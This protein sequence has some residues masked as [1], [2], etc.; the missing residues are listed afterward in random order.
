MLYLFRRTA[1]QGARDVVESLQE[2]G[3]NAR[4]LNDLGRAHFGQGVRVGDFVVC[5]GEGG[6][7]VP[8]GVQILNN[9][10]VRTKYNDAVTLRDAGVPTITVSQ[11]RPIVR[12]IQPVVD[13]FVA[14]S[15][16]VRELV[17][18]FA[19]VDWVRGPVLRD[20]IVEVLRELNAINTINNTPPPPP[21]M[22]VPTPD[23]V[24]RRNN[25]VGGNDLLRPPTT[26]DYYV[27]KEAITQEYRVHSF[28]GKS[29]RAGQKVQR[30]GMTAHPWIRSFDGGWMISYDGFESTG[31]MRELAARAVSALGLDFGAV[32]IAQ[33]LDN[34]L[35]VLEVNRAPGSEGGTS[36]AYA[37]AI[38]RWMNGEFNQ[39]R[40]ARPR[41]QNGQ[42]AAAQTRRA[43]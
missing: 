21:T 26:P 15:V 28:K 29:I 33:L 8:Q 7:T 22:S 9:V 16:R 39:E 1:S 42:P 14:E 24:G 12:A 23:W 27:Q 17:G 11:N 41:R 35:I 25:H 32:D 38:N 36:N 6:I 5:W 10:P 43:A 13:P 18:G 37:S 3:V 30:P 4:R 19:D 2:N 40:Q 31:P 34:R 20:S